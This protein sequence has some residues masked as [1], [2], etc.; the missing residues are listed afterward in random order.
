MKEIAWRLGANA[1]WNTHN[2][3]KACPQL[4]DFNNGIWRNMEELTQKWADKYGKV[5]VICGPIFM[6]G[7]PKTYIGD[8]EEKQIP[9]PDAFYKIVIRETSNG[10]LDALA[11]IYKHK[12]VN[13]KYNHK[14]YLVRIS[15]I[16]KLTGIKFLTALPRNEREALEEKKTIDI[17]S[18]TNE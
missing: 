18:E 15:D 12:E 16:E 1:D 8:E 17:W 11:F 2:M 5:W 10:K 4:H 3:L 9:V 6:S 14:N 13:G 7:V